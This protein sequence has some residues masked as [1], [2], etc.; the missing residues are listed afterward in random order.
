MSKFDHD[1]WHDCGGGVM[2]RGLVLA[3]V[4]GF[5]LKVVGNWRGPLAT[6]V[7][8]CGSAYISRLQQ[9]NNESGTFKRT[10]YE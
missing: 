2:R 1:G 3:G 8:V 10:R 6:L 9:G 5:V 7:G 4:G